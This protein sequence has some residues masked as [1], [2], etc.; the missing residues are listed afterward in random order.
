MTCFSIGWTPPKK[1]GGCPPL[2]GLELTGNDSHVSLGL[3]RAS[4]PNL[5]NGLDVSEE[6]RV[7]AYDDVENGDG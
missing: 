4:I 3:G 5:Q 6:G 7:I 2:T 1:E